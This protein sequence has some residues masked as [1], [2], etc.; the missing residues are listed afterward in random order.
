M[1]LLNTTPVPLKGHAVFSLP[2]FHVWDNFFS[3]AVCEALSHHGDG[4]CL[5]FIYFTLVWMAS[6]PVL[7]VKLFTRL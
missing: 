7:K 3:S 4:Q 2:Y 5:S 1:T 6:P